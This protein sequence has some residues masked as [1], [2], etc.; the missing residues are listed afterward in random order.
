MKYYSSK[1]NE[2]FPSATTLME[3]EDIVL[4]NTNALCYYL[5]VESKK[6]YRVYNKKQK[7][8]DL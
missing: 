6:Y 3:L 1:K 7:E 4:R 2:I 8:T 5:Y